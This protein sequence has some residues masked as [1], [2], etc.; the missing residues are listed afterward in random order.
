MWEGGGSK[1]LSRAL[2]HAVLPSDANKIILKHCKVIVRG[3][4]ENQMTL[5]NVNIPHYDHYTERSFIQTLHISFTQTL[6]HS[7]THFNGH[8]FTMINIHNDVMMYLNHSLLTPTRILCKFLGFAIVTMI[9]F[10][11]PALTAN[12]TLTTH[13]YTTHI[14]FVIFCAIA[15]STSTSHLEGAT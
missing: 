12:A 14:V 9:L 13:M 15:S 10:V 6:L 7:H 4:V 1:R 8:A 3:G 5:A 2:G 11:A